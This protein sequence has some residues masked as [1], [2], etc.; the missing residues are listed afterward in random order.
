MCLLSLNGHS[1]TL[2]VQYLKAV[3]EYIFPSFRIAY[4]RKDSPVPVTQS[5][6]K[7]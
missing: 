4:G 2:S 1:L 7:G 3:D 5:W 6:P